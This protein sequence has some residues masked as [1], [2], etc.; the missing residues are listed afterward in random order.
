M[1]NGASPHNSERELDRPLCFCFHVPARKVIN[2]VRQRRP[3]RASQISECFGAGTGCGWCIPFLRRIHEQVLATG[4]VEADDV[5]PAEYEAMRRRYLEGI[6]AGTRARH[7]A[8]TSELPPEYRAPP[9][10]EAG[11]LPRSEKDR[12]DDDWDPS[13]YFSRPSPAEPEPDLLED[14]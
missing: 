5:T 6:R 11:P 8:E 14:D 7:T 2:F 12:E 4:R 13:H 9:T 1:P 3:P 10:A